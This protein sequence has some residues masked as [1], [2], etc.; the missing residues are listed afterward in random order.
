MTKTSNYP[1]A[2][3]KGHR[4]FTTD[5]VAERGSEAVLEELRAQFQAAH[6]EHRQYDGWT[7]GTVL[8]EVTLTQGGF[9]T[10]VRAEVGD[11]VLMKPDPYP[12]GWAGCT[13][14][15]TFYVPRV[16]WNC[17]FTYGWRRLDRP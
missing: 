2:A 6:A 8:A 5:D 1:E 9:N 12:Y 16:G 17:M 3:A 15:H 10:F 7:D 13:P 14:N 11:V 4:V